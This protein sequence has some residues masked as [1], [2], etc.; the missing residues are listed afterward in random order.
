M[1]SELEPDMI[2]IRILNNILGQLPVNVY[3]KD[4][5]LAF[6]LG[7]GEF[8]A[9]MKTY[10]QEGKLSVTVHDEVAASGNIKLEPCNSYT[11]IVSGE[12]V[13]NVIVSLYKDNMMCPK[14]GYGHIRFINSVKGG[15]PVDVYIDEDK[16][17]S[18]I[19]YEHT[20][21]PVY[22]PVKIAP[23][24][25]SDA[26]VLSYNEVIIKSHNTDQVL[27]GPLPL[28]LIN[29]GIY[30]LILAGPSLLLSHDNP[31]SCLGLQKD[32]N[33]EA[34][35][36]KWNVIASISPQTG[37]MTTEFTLLSDR[38]KV[39]QTWYGPHNEPIDTHIGAAFAPNPCL[40]AALQLVFP[41]MAPPP[42]PNYLIL[43]TDYL[44]YAVIGS[45][46]LSS[47]YILSR[48]STINADIYK[49]LLALG[50]EL[51]YNMS[52]INIAC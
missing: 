27:I 2:E 50:D 29:R 4:Q 38:I 28:Y 1:S 40:P 47:F 46:T 14:L 6:G 30:T 52:Q 51:N 21:H 25:N 5:M 31:D 43:R 16:I 35:M 24:P 48:R 8:T 22:A 26:S 44:S 42:G 10:T 11:A 33:T 41:T 17:G 13:K 3:L 7:Y 45:P 19:K 32:F 34:F 37:R 9:Y 12:N 15:Q 49:K 36:G 23:E 39:V 20:G 18:N